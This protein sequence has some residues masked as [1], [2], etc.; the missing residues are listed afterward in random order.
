MFC[1][2]LEVMLAK[3][4]L[5]EQNYVMLVL[6]ASV[7]ALGS[8]FTELVLFLTKQDNFLKHAYQL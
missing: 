5:L 2:S 3:L 1:S 8:F 7:N 4:P 6:R